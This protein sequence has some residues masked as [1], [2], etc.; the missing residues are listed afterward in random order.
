MSTLSIN[1]L[2]TILIFAFL[3]FGL[4]Y[5]ILGNNIKYGILIFFIAIYLV[6][7]FTGYFISN[8]SGQKNCNNSFKKVC[9][10]KAFK[11]AFYS[12]LVYCLIFFIPFFK[13]GFIGLLG[14]TFFSNS[15]SEAVIIVLTNISLTIDNY[16][17]S[18]KEN[19]KLDFDL[20]AAAWRRVEKKL[21]SRKKKKEKNMVEVNP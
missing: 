1:I 6:S 20:S 13:S 21:N 12:T 5:F 19:C 7:F 2:V 14:N 9:F 3:P 11:Q 4:N 15:L 8:Y 18:I 17:H 16:F 10:W